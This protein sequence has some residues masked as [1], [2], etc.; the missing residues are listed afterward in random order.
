VSFEELHATGLPGLL[1]LCLLAKDGKSFTVAHQVFEESQSKGDPTLLSL[2]LTFAS[3][4]FKEAHEA[5]WL[6]REILKMKDL[7][8]ESIVYRTGEAEGE[9]RGEAKGMAKGMAQGMIILML[10]TIQARYPALSTRAKK[11]LTLIQDPETIHRLTKKIIGA[12]SKKEVERYLREI[13]NS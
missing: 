6:G 10:E 4:V 11:Q 13:G 12:R 8:T 3:L 5:E 2:A 1:P 7:F 9:A